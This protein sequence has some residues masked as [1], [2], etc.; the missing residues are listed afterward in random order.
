MQDDEAF[1]RSI[2]IARWTNKPAYT[3][4]V[5]GWAYDQTGRFPPIA[6]PDGFTKPSMKGCRHCSNRIAS[7]LP[8][9]VCPVC[10]IVLSDDPLRLAAMRE[11]VLAGESMSGA[12]KLVVYGTKSDWDCVYGPLKVPVESMPPVGNR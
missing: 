4:D 12:A 8:D 6:P 2:D 5:D 11:L 10:E 3:R 1:D 9:P 7:A